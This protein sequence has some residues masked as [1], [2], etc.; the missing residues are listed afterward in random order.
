MVIL[1]EKP[2]DLG[3]LTRSLESFEHFVGSAGHHS[4]LPIGLR[5]SWL[6]C[7]KMVCAVSRRLGSDTATT[8]YLAKS[9]R[10]RNAGIV[11]PLL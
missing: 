4:A 2:D 8:P 7:M 3:S 10:T 1:M 9:I 5:R 6:G 11:E